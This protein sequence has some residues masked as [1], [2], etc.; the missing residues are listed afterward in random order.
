LIGLCSAAFATAAEINPLDYNCADYIRADERFQDWRQTVELETCDRVQRLARIAVRSARGDVPR[1]FIETIAAEKIP[2]IGVDIPLVRVVFPQRVFFDTAES[3]LR[4]EARQVVDFVAETLRWDLPDVAVFIAGHTDP[5]GD[6]DYNYNLSIDRANTVASA[7]RNAGIA[8]GTIWRVGFGPDMPLVPNL[9]EES[10]GYNRR[11]EFLFAAKVEA[12]A[13]WLADIQVDGLCQA[14]DEAAS[15]ACKRE[16]RL[17]SDYT[18]VEVLSTTLTAQ[19]E[20]QQSIAVPDAGKS[21]VDPTRGASTVTP[22]ATEPVAV[23]PSVNTV[24]PTPKAQM[25]VINPVSRTSRMAEG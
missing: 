5:R 9:D 11:V 23:K 22:G 10:W 21:S 16:L 14:R 2:Q 17:R 6:W 3:E 1:F 7:L 18:A 25:I 15:T 13:V 8:T 19:P 20:S 4:P 12:V 24:A